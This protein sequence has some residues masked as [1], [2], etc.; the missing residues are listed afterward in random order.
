MITPD[1]L[2]MIIHFMLYKYKRSWLKHFPNTLRHI[3]HTLY[4]YIHCQSPSTKFAA[5]YGESFFPSIIVCKHFLF[6]KI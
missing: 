2:L 1:G 4:F 5:K 3:E 6:K